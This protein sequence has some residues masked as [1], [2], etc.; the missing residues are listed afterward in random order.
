[1]N[2]V[3]QKRHGREQLARF[4]VLRFQEMATDQRCRSLPQWHTV[5]TIE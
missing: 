2:H 1:M 4:E 3:G 5:L